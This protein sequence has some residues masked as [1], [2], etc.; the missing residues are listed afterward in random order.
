MGATGPWE[1]SRGCAGSHL[2]RRRGCLSSQNSFIYVSDKMLFSFLFS[3][4]I[5]F[6]T[7][8]ESRQK[9]EDFPHFLVQNRKLDKVK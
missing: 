8:P 1:R 5:I 3:S 7:S 9:E 6:M 4:H 2:P